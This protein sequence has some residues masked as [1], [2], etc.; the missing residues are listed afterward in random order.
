MRLAT[1]NLFRPREP[2][3][4]TYPT[5]N[6]RVMG[7]QP[8]SCARNSSPTTAPPLFAKT[9]ERSLPSALE[10]RTGVRSPFRRFLGNKKAG[11]EGP[12]FIGL[13]IS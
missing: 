9:S 3:S 6:A 11:R 10:G 13:R 7:F 12:A 5:S 4:P 8:M 2:Y 1:T